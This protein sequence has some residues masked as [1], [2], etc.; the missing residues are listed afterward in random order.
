MAYRGHL[1]RRLTQVGDQPALVALVARVVAPVAPVDLFH[2]VRV[3][4]GDPV[5]QVVP[6][7]GLADRVE[8]QEVPA[9]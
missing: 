3:V 4:Q 5:A 1:G 9:E 2:G 8:V 6:V 7:E